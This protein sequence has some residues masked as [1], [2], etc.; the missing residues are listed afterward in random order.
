MALSKSYT[1]K[2]IRDEIRILANVLF[3]DKVDDPI[4]NKI[5]H[6]HTF[7][8]ADQLNDIPNYGE[9]TILA[10]SSSSVS[11]TIKTGATY[12]NSTKTINYVGHGLDSTDIGK[13]I[14]YGKSDFSL[15]AIAQIE[16]IIDANNFVVSIALGADTSG[17][18]CDYT[19]LSSFSGTYLDLSNV[20]FSKIIKL[21]DSINGLVS[22]RPDLDFENLDNIE[23]YDNSLMYNQFG[24]K[25]ILFKGRNIASWG[26]LTLYYYRL[27][28]LPAADTDYIDISDNNIPKLIEMCRIDLY[29]LSNNA[30]P[31]PPQTDKTK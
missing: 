28:D 25:L 17:G 6:K 16:S 19:V 3:R 5:I 26:T 11:T 4:L 12:T 29:N 18:G 2:D 27:P 22:A 15:I 1:L 31:Q 23:D 10:D 7:A 20:N 13:R 24:E 21:V 14:I 8:L 30:I 9:T